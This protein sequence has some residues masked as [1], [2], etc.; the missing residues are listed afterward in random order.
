[1]LPQCVT[2]AEDDTKQT[3]IVVLEAE[4]KQWCVPNMDMCIKFKSFILTLKSQDEREFLFIS[5]F[6]SPITTT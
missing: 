3:S 4:C 5:M 6:I 1:M 2:Q